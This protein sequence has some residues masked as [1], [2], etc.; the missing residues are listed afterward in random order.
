MKRSSLL[1]L[2]GLVFGGLTLGSA[3]AA[4]RGAVFLGERS[5]DFRADHDV[6]QVGRYDGFF[7]SLVFEVERNNIEIFNIVV[8]YGDGQRERLDTR[9]VF[10]AGM[11]SRAIRFEGGRRKIRSVAFEFRTVGS[12]L[13]GRARVRVLGLR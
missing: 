12:W 10:D 11:R 3:Y 13:E 8:T 9:L 7:R 4:P 6:I 1:L 5:V 2:V